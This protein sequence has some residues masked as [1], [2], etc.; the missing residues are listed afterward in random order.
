MQDENKGRICVAQFVLPGLIWC[1]FPA[2]WETPF[3]PQHFLNIILT[4]NLLKIEI[5]L[6]KCG[7]HVQLSHVQHTCVTGII[8]LKLLVVDYLLIH[9]QP[10]KSDK[11]Q[12]QCVNFEAI[13]P[14]VSLW[15]VYVSMLCNPLSKK[16]LLLSL[17]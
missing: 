13:Q 10:E 12:E 6:G 1:M 5:F 3:I 9:E 17:G 7:I 4:G 2:R 8:V 15:F 11:I 14:D 16:D